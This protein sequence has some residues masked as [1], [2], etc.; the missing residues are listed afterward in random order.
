MSDRIGISRSSNVS[1]D[2]VLTLGQEAWNIADGFT[3]VKIL[4]IL[5]ELDLYENL[6]LFGYQTV[7]DMETTPTELIPRKRVEALNRMAFDL[8]QL[9]GNC[10]FSIDKQQDRMIVAH[11]FA[12]LDTVEKFLDGSYTSTRNYVTHEDSLMI[13]EEHFKKCFDIM[14]N[15]K[16]ELNFPINRAGLIFK[17]TDTTDLDQ[18]T[19]DLIEGG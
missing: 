13:N 17:Q 2:G 11:L 19:K 9:I 18:L 7:E 6:A 10:R 4:R 1:G 3:K 5:I 16:D 14:R 12:R 8:R 15:I